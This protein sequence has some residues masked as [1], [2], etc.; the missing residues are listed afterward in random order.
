MDLCEEG[1][2]GWDRAVE[3]CENAH[4]AAP[5][6]TSDE[7]MGTKVTLF[8]ELGYRRMSK[9]ER[10]D[11]TYWHACLAYAQGEAMNNRSL[12]ERFGL[13]DEQKNTV[14]VSRLIKECCNSD[15]IKEEDP[16]AGA[17]YRR[18]IPFWA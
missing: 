5:K 17:K 1:G 2:T 13:A 16:E 14:A 4:L 12:R 9:K 8:R 3:A 6:I 7:E 18:Y 15:L 11:A 10:M